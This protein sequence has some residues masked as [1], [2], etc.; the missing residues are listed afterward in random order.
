MV[1]GG[2]CSEMTVD[3][4]IMG[5]SCRSMGVVVSC[6]TSELEQIRDSIMAQSGATGIKEPGRS[7]GTPMC[8][9]LVCVVFG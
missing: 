9:V 2:S 4:L 7:G 5:A 3:L 1:W 8:T 6:V